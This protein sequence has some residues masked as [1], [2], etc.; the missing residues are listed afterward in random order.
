MSTSNQSGCRPSTRQA[1]PSS[2]VSWVDN[3]L[4]VR[5]QFH[6]RF[7]YKFFVRTMF[8]AAF[9]R[10]VSAL[11]PKFRMKNA[12]VNVDE[13]DGRLTK[14]FFSK[15]VLHSSRQTFHLPTWILGLWFYSDGYFF[16][17]SKVRCLKCIYHP[18]QLL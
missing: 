10:Y 17:I 2:R 9:S 15:R 6:Q 16:Q 7:T 14:T 18:M 13:I 3:F 5:C 12:C 11:A 8:L 4:S 1:R